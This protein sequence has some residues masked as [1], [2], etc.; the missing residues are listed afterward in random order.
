MTSPSEPRELFPFVIFAG[1]PSLDS[2]VKDFRAQPVSVDDA[3]PNQDLV[4]LLEAVP[5]P[6]SVSSVT[7]NVTPSG[8][9]SFV[10]P[11]PTQTI[12]TIESPSPSGSEASPASVEKDT[13]T[14]GRPLL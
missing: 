12:T 2:V 11:T 1:R 13:Q 3:L 6:K 4:R 14:T 8:Q 5:D 10:T 7:G 9:D